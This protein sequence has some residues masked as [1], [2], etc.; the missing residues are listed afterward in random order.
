MMMYTTLC[1]I[2]LS[3]SK[4]AVM[5][6]LGTLPHNAVCRTYADQVQ[7]TYIY[8]ILTAYPLVP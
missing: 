7:T 8:H 2:I 5:V 3:V 4:A 1:C 6:K